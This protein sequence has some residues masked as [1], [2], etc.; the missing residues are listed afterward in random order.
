MQPYGR[1]Q[2]LGTGINPE[3]FKQDY[4]GF[5]RAAGI[6]AQG[7]ADLGA[8]IGGV[9]KDFGDAKK[10][11]KKVEASNK[12]SAKAI[13]AAMTLGDSYGVSGAR[14]TLSPFLEAYNDPSRSS[15]EKAALLEEAKAMI[16]NVFSRFDQ[17]QAMA[18]KNAELQARMAPSMAEPLR[19]TPKMIKTARGDLAV[20]ESNDGSGM[21]YDPET[22]L[23]IV[24]IPAFGEGLPPENWTAP[25]NDLPDFQG[26]SVNDFSAPSVLPDRSATE[27]A[28]ENAL[29]LP[30]V[31]S[32]EVPEILLNTRVPGMPIDAAKNIQGLIGE[33][34]Q[35]PSRRP[36][37]IA[38]EPKGPLVNISNP[39][40]PPQGYMNV[41]DD[42]GNLIRQ[43]PTPG[44]PVEREE[45]ESKVA[46]TKA[47]EDFSS[48]V[49]QMAD[50]YARLNEKGKAVAGGEMNP[51]NYV[52]ATGP[53][54]VFSRMLGS[55]SQVLRDQINTMRPAII[56]V[57][58]Q[59]SEM[60]AKGMD[61]EKELEF[62]LSSLGD[63]RLPVEANIKALDVLDKVYGEGKA[64]KTILKD[65][66][67]L[68]KKVSGYNLKMPAT[69]A[70]EQIGISPAAQEAM[71]IIRGQ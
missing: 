22:R 53:G 36:R 35:V 16:P 52:E 24:N 6:Q 69:T 63:P 5:A 23:P 4:S 48:Y 15:I 60:G 54:Q 29:S 45:K 33:G 64:V 10:E 38:G 46:Q 1:G 19:F 21:Y 30:T 25:L 66:P 39:P 47:K 61:S 57:I 27:G 18:I 26:S 31:G 17:S 59:A 41:F 8:S 49:Q 13:E 56:N 9:I 42:S 32:G 7:M 12:A 34:D 71:K 50:S 14:E 28:I 68:L 2:T 3:S 65:Y 55:E 11:Q 67:E 40:T 70:S 58:R 43:E 20:M 37:Y 51:L 44:G 62:Y